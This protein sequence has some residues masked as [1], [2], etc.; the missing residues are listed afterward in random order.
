MSCSL[1]RRY[2]WGS[3]DAWTTA[4]NRAS[5]TAWG[6]VTRAQELRSI[7]EVMPSQPS[8]R[9]IRA[10]EPGRFSYGWHIL[11][12]GERITDDAGYVVTHHGDADGFW[13]EPSVRMD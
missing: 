1:V 12:E 10:P 11:D 3:L 6:R 4:S 9:T 7:R 2:F 8:R 5:H 13:G